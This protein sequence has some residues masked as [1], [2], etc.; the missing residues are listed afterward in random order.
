MGSQ[1]EK[2]INEMSLR[3]GALKILVEAGTLQECQHHEGNFFQGTAD[4]AVAFTLA[5]SVLSQE[6]S[7]EA[8]ER[9]VPKIG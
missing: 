4:I 3:R 8:G 6:A 1:K 7:V 5:N 2:W 9:R